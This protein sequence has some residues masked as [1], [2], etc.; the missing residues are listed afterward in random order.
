LSRVPT[1]YEQGPGCRSVPK[2]PARRKG[3]H[4]TATGMPA[5]G[6]SAKEVMKG[7]QRER[8]SPRRRWPDNSNARRIDR[9]RP[10]PISDGDD[11][12]DVTGLLGVVL[13]TGE[14]GKVFGGVGKRGS[15]HQEAG[16]CPG[17][18]ERLVGRWVHVP[19]V[20][21]YDQ[22][23]RVLAVAWSGGGSRSSARGPHVCRDVA[24]GRACP[25]WD[26]RG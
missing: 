14:P 5:P 23:L 6:G 17:I 15:G 11:E 8:P 18:E 12:G 25:G 26:Q 1:C 22:R 9:P 24:P 16:G 7:E 2:A 3:S 13:L 4:R 10:A 21:E 19:S 20:G